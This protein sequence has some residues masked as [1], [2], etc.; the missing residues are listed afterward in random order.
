MVNFP[1]ECDGK[2]KE[3]EL[4]YQIQGFLLQLK[5]GWLELV[6][7]VALFL[8]KTG[9]CDAKISCEFFVEAIFCFV[10]ICFQKRGTYTT[11]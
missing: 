11:L 7:L 4:N 10:K 8:F 1:C 5:N 9:T 2:S 3:L 6:E